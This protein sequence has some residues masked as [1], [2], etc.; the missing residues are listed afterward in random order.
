M[1][2]ASG[3][4]LEAE[5][6]RSDS[7]LGEAGGARRDGVRCAVDFIEACGARR[8]ATLSKPGGARS[9]GDLSQAGVAGR[10]AD[11][12][13]SGG[14]LPPLGK[15]MEKSSVLAFTRQSV[16][17]ARQTERKRCWLGRR[18]RQAI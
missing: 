13:E 5:G 9:V 12:H 11:F 17:V 10:V 18:R 16:R 14:G 2:E 8:G 6:A 15:P 7:L 1:G 4:R 3:T